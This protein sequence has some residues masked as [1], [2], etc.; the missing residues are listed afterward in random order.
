MYQETISLPPTA[1]LRQNNIQYSDKAILN[2]WYH[3]TKLYIECI[4]QV[5]HAK[6]FPIY[7]D[8]GQDIAKY[9]LKMIEIK[10]REAG[11]QFSLTTGSIINR[12]GF[13][14][15]TFGLEIDLQRSKL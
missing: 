3:T 12:R 14:F 10:F 11:Y 4:H 8:L 5:Y 13:S 1:S 15:D 9:D 6:S 2:T 7:M